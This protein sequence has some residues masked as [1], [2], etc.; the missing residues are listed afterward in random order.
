MKKIFLLSLICALMVP[1]GCTDRPE[2]TETRFLLDTFLTLSADC[3]TK[4]LSEV[5]D[6]CADY[7]K[8]FSRTV[9]SSP[10]SRLNKGEVLTVSDDLKAVLEAGLKYGEISGGKF[11]ITIC[12]V[13]RLWDFEN[14]V[15]PERAALDKALK[16]VHY[17]KVFVNGHTVSLGGTEIDLGG[18]AKGYIADRLAEKLK[19][20][21][22]KNGIINFS[23]SIVV[24]GKKR[25]V[26]LHDP[27]SADTYAATLA[28]Q[29]ISVSTS[30]TYERCFT[31]D[32]VH[33]HHILDPPT[34]YGVQTDL[35]SATVLC[36]S[37]M[38]GDAIS[39]VCILYG[40]EKATEWIESLPE[41]E[42]VFIDEKGHLTYTDGI[43]EKDGLLILKK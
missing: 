8:E 36:D 11:D 35:L 40:L 37:A 29:N 34:G 28:V 39:T 18:I 13:S 15:L 17:R 38:D 24:F 33:Y 42:A 16:R 1:C 4:T 43:T 22:V 32:N 26:K 6:A 41:T 12:P 21:G 2:N 30:G 3:D 27:L 5:F 19:A 9:E 23:S 20:K 10:V 31:K 7:E 25:Q 14:A